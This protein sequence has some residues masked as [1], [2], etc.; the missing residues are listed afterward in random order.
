M[1]RRLAQL[2]AELKTQKE[3][4]KV[5]KEVIQDLAKEETLELVGNPLASASTARHTTQGTLTSSS[6]KYYADVTY[7]SH[8]TRSTSQVNSWQINTP[9]KVNSATLEL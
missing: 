5:L 6:P 2:E 4:V 1:H 3:I 9:Y 8:R 7:G